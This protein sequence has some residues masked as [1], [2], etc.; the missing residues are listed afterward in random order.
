MKH[1]KLTRWFTPIFAAFLMLG[2][3]A[4]KD[5]N[6]DDID[7]YYTPYNLAVTSF[8]L[9][10]DDSVMANLDSVFFSIDLKNKVI[11]NADSLP[12]GT[13]INK[14]VPTVEYSSSSYVNGVKFIMEGGETRTGETDYLDS[15][16]D[17][18]DFTG[19]VKL[20]L[21]SETQ[22][23]DFVI[24]YK[25]K[26]LVHK[27]KA[28]SLMWGDRAYAKLPSRLG[29][30]LNQ[31]TID[32]NG[33]AVSLIQES[34]G[35]YTFAR[36]SNLYDSEWQKNAVT[37]PFTPDVR[38]LTA[39]SNK[40]IILD[41]DGNMYESADGINWSA[42]GQKWTAIIGTYIDSAIGLKSGADGLVY[43]Q[44]PLKDLLETAIDPEF[45]VAN[46]SNFVI[47]QNKWTT[48]PV[49]FFAGGHK[50]NGELS[51]ATWAFDGKSWIKLAEGG[52]PGLEGAS[53][54][55]Y[56]G[57]RFTNSDYKQTEYPVWMILGGTKSDKTLNRT[58]YISY[59]NGVNWGEG[60]ALMQLP[61]EI[62]T[63]TGCDNVVMYTPRSSK[64][65]DYWTRAGGS[66]PVVDGD[67]LI[68]DCPYIYLI[69]GFGTN[70][71]LYDSVWRGVL[72]RLTFTPII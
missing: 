50:S 71:A 36:S 27:E 57:Y 10:A 53:M 30:P 26:V 69:G 39:T 66:T 72:A 58:I 59:D 43:A 41:S 33:E 3:N 38:S 32:F 65:S 64:L 40:V 5:N 55:P 67:N 54:I 61:K 29:S 45:P 4:C 24:E 28:D 13:K 2:A 51:N 15:P 46:G 52:I 9:N 1:T 23:G 22:E 8:T 37:F 17:S 18:I 42:T 56:Y 47:L 31:K 11:F 63:M 25:V 48:S 68:W 35:S 14:L 62:P 34:D 7:P 44:Y 49:G 6:T 60:N 70:G 21:I 16:T 12:V 20:K 19:N